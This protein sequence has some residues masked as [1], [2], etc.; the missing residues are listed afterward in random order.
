MKKLVIVR[1]KEWKDGFYAMLKAE[2]NSVKIIKSMF[3]NFG[4]QYFVEEKRNLSDYSQWKDLWIPY[5][6]KDEKI[7]LD[8][9]FGDKYIHL[10]VRKYKDKV[11]IEKIMKKYCKKAKRT[12]TLY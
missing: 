5:S 1:K 11:F 7:D 10:I 8:L 6:D 3:E 4:S 12:Y 2:K 9:V